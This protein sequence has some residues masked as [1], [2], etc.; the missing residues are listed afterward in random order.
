M[1]YMTS[2]EAAEKWGV[3]V[4]QVQRLL[5]ANRIPGIK[6][7]GRSQLIPKGAEKPGDPRSKEYDP[8]NSLHFK[9]AEIIEA[10]T[11]PM[12]SDNPGS[13]LDT[14]KEERLQLHYESEIA[15]LRGDFESVKD[16]FHKTEGDSASRLRA[17]S[18]AIAAAISTGDY[19][20]YLEIENHLKNVISKSEDRSV[21]AF[22]EL[23]LSNAYLSAAAPNIAP[24][25]LKNGDFSNLHNKAKPDAVYKRAK[26][27]QATG[28][29]ES[30]L[31]TSETALTFC[32]FTGGVSFY[33]I[34]FRVICAIAC[35]ALGRMDEATSWLQSAMKI[36]LPHGF[37]TP[38]AESATAFGG[39]MEKLLKKEY[40]AHHD[41]ITEQWNS[42]YVNWRSFHNSF[43]KH[44]ITLI[45]SL[46]DYEIALFVARRVPYAKIAEHFNMSLGRTKNKIGEIYAE[47]L[48]DNREDL[49]ELIL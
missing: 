40:P 28:K 1:E 11:L 13:I 3:T 21:I 9:L 19:P 4:R 25:W 49:K 18:V 48:I 22:A 32:G 35:C 10:T 20:L 12:P 16:C 30:M 5:A 27:F 24:D 46:R 47:L 42:T 15:Y 43:T 2:A 26:Y 45:L 7:Y 17:C 33:D 41:D 44:N 6:K 34:Y 14:T 8:N 29:F 23:S 36:A 39:L 37:I 38:F 31:A